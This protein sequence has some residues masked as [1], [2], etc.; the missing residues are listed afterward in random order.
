MLYKVSN[1]NIFFPLKNREYFLYNTR[2]AAILKVDNEFKNA[3][4]NKEFDQFPEDFVHQLLIMGIFLNSN[5][6]E[7]K[8]LINDYYN[9]LHDKQS[10]HFIILPTYKCNF[11]CKYC[12]EG[13]GDIYSGTMDKQ[14]AKQVIESIKN[15][16]NY[17]NS[18]FLEITLFG[19]EPMLNTKIGNFLITQLR[20]W[21]QEKNIEY[22]SSIV[23]NG[24]LIKNSEDPLL[25]N[26]D[27][28]RI[29]LDGSETIH[30]KKRVKKDGSGTFNDI[31]RG[32]KILKGM[33]K[34]ISLRIQIGNDNKTDIENLMDYLVQNN[35]INSII[36]DPLIKIDFAPLFEMSNLCGTYSSYLN[37]NEV[38]E[39]AS[40]IS[41]YNTTAV[42]SP[43]L[44]PCLVY[45]NVLAI[46]PFGDVYKCLSMLGEKENRIGYIDDNNHIIFEYEY[47]DF[48]SRSPW[49]FENCKDCKY[50]PICGGNCP[51][52]SKLLH[53]TYHK[54][55]CQSND[56]IIYQYILGF[57]ERTYPQYF[58]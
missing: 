3:L 4:E 17:N 47:E 9:K 28:F 51:R 54:A 50:L 29:T 52:T 48:L 46:D 26:L 7:L 10:A 34:N 2:T 30:N 20:I 18:K 25:K 32:I 16:I 45:G 55:V 43:Q 38:I 36:G 27:L 56:K 58:N 19:G 41:K 49:K 8:I 22:R 44:L 5:S 31:I 15:Y 37:K 12:F 13:S 33:N 21:A 39:I 42:P 40:I 6:D 57:L 11:A 14:T 35:I 23:T 53:G 1:Y 24:S